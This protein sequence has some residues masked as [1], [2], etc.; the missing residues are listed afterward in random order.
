MTTTVQ[1]DVSFG[2]DMPETD[3][4]IHPLGGGWQNARTWVGTFNITPITGDGYQLMRIAG[5]IAMNDPW[6]VTGD[7]VERFRFEIITSGTESMNLQA[8][9][10]QG[11][12]DLMWTQNDFEML[13][14]FNLY[15]STSQNGTYIRLNDS[16]IIPPRP[17]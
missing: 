16:F 9:G 7:D 13:A 5:A 14:G 12:V 3:Y 6:L 11:Y 2:P 1:P 4:T 17:A 8:T 10:G 15:K